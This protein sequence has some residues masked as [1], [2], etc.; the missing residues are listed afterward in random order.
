MLEIFKFCLKLHVFEE[1]L[2][3]I[4]WHLQHD[5]GGRAHMFVDVR[6]GILWFLL[7]AVAL[8]VACLLRCKWP[9]DQPSP[10]APSFM[11]NFSLFN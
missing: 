5:H 4:F 1:I 10:Q 2:E 8:L 7:G 6:V 9:R 3:L 11:K